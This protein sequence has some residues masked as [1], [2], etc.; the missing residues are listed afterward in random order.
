MGLHS[1]HRTVEYRNKQ[2][3]IPFADPRRL[4]IYFH[5]FSP[6]QSILS[7]GL[8][9]QQYLVILW[10]SIFLVEEIGVPGENRRLVASH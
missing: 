3:Y 2:L 4:V 1:S 6:L 10:R 5:I 7:F 9:F 8:Q